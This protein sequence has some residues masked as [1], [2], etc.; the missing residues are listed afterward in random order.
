LDRKNNIFKKNIVSIF[1][2]KLIALLF[3]YLTVPLLIKTLGVD[4]Y[5]IWITIYSI[6]GWIYFL[7]LGIGNGLKN[8]LTIA[9]LKNNNDAKEY[10]TTS[11][12][13][14][15]LVAIIFFI[16]FSILIY[17]L[18]I[19]TL[20][21]IQLEE[22]YLKTLFFITLLSFVFVFV[23][24]IYKQ[25]FYAL[26]KSSVVE[27]SMMIYSGIVFLLLYLFMYNFK[28]SLISTTIIYGVSN[29]LICLLF[30]YLFFKGNREFWFSF[31]NFNVQKIR[32]LSGI[33][34]DF[35]VIQICVLIILAT[36][37]ILNIILLG[38]ADVTSYNNVF[39]LFQ[40]FL[41]TSTLIQTP[42][43]SLYTDAYH[44]NDIEWIKRTI[45]RLNY[46]IIPLIL[47]VALTIYLG[48]KILALWINEEIFYE[49]KL[50]LFM[51][52]FVIIRIYGEIYIYFLNGIGKI[53]LQ[54]I[55]SIF[56][57]IINIPLSIIFVKYFNLGNSGIILATVI[58][59]SLYVVVM[60]IQA[61]SILNKKGS[62][63]YGQKE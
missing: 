2:Y 34:I 14:L 36:D 22:W 12:L 19:G 45:K 29:I 57:A 50:L 52:L 20:L 15:T 43:W 23:L 17:F 11:Y 31:K 46:L 33:S 37:N 63:V 27:L 35:F 16:V 7:D 56:A 10:I 26:Q 59:M 5:G 30:T 18:D 6:F 24:S 51:G 58:S 39:K 1:F 9:F 4:Q 48:P 40:L 32:E 61:V 38:P 41:I 3:V 49:P 42:L 8:K 13:C 54:L 28:S 60:P 21:N 53:K 55:V 47:L 44:N 25:F 62:I